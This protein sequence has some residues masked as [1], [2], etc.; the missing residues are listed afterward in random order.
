[1]RQFKYNTKSLIGT[2]ILALIGT[3]IFW[4]T[5]FS[6]PRAEQNPAHGP[7]TFVIMASPTSTTRYAVMTQGQNSFL[8]LQEALLANNVT[9]T[10]KEY[11]GI[12]NLI[13]QIGDLKNGTNGNYWQF[14]IN[15]QYATSA[16]D[17]YV[18]MGGDVIEWKFMNSAEQ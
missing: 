8:L 17:A 6:S 15:D 5:L 18:P 14:F 13:T 7:V 10:Y 2:V 9:F 4:P 3:A 1:M 12:G 16:A 11:A